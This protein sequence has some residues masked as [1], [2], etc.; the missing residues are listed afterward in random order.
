MIGDTSNQ[1]VVA[2]NSL[3]L[4]GALDDQNPRD[5]IVAIPPE[6]YF[7]VNGIH[8]YRSRF[9][10]DE[11][12]GI[13]ILGANILMGHDVLFDID[14]SRIGFAESTCNYTALTAAFPIPPSTLPER[15]ERLGDPSED[16]DTIMCSTQTCQYGT[17]G[18]VTLAVIV[19]VRRI[20]QRRQ[21]SYDRVAVDEGGLELPADSNLTIGER[22]YRDDGNKPVES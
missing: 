10:V 2:A 18:L 1:G 13:S 6:H 3:R 4:V 7:E 15:E 12:G 14:R 22:G 11:R 5:I 21:R 8:S 20:L 9:Y 17:L 16:Y 19:L